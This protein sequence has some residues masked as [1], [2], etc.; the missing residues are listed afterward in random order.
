MSRYIE[1]A[2]CEECPFIKIEEVNEIETYYCNHDAVKNKP[3]SDRIVFEEETILDEDKFPKICP[4]K[5]MFWR[6]S[7]D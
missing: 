5:K 6:K 2:G 3:I 4:L 1:I 7:E